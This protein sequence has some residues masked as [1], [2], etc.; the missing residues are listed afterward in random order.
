M[1]SIQQ[2]THVHPN[3]TRALDSV[4]LEIPR[5][6]FDMKTTAATTR[7]LPNGSFELT[8]EIQAHKRYADRQGRETE[9]LLDAEVNV[10]AF[11]V[12]PG[13]A[14]FQA[15]SVLALSR[16]RI[17]SNSEDNLKAVSAQP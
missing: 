2:L 6:M 8:I 14:G 13:K 16:P 1:L 5:G 12:E 3:G 9:A 4:T 7:K 17:V 15:D 10:G 11:S